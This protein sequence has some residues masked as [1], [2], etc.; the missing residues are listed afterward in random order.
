M[1]ANHTVKSNHIVEENQTIEAI[2][3]YVLSIG[4]N[5]SEANVVAA[6]KWLRTLFADMEVSHVYETPAISSHGS[7]APCSGQGE[8]PVYD[9]AVACVESPMGCADLESLLKAYELEC[10]RDAK[11]RAAG[12]VPIDIDI[13]VTDGSIKRPW[14]YRQHFFK[15]GYAT[16]TQHATIR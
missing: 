9:N 8:I 4:S 1:E 2:H 16:I 13:V 10:G 7:A 14:D 11:A 5:V 12:I 15:I 6:I 3:T